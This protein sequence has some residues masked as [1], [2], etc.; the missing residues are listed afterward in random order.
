[1]FPLKRIE[2]RVKEKTANALSTTHAFDHLKRTAV[3]ARWFAELS[4]G[5]KEECEKAFL[6]GLLH[7]VYRPPSEKQHEE[8]LSKDYEEAK[9]ILKEFNLPAQT[10]EEI[11]QPI[12][13]HREKFEGKG[14][15][16]QCVFLA[17]KI[18]EDMGALIVFRRNIY[19]GENPEYKGVPLQ[20]AIARQYE[21]RL[22]KFTPKDFPARFSKLAQYQYD[23]PLN[24]LAAY[25]K[26]EDWAV[27]LAEYCYAKGKEKAEF[28]ESIKSFQPKWK[29]D[30]KHKEEALQYIQGKKFKQFEEMIE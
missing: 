16:Y 14:N 22:A 2:E 26:R 17:D 27:H 20:E 19:L 18:L 1:M 28:E 4:G 24:F 21:K 10:I 29:K 30:K 8:S 3:G 9:Q 12:K 25:K 6:S 5:S 15:I 7:D 13:N 23:W 11:A